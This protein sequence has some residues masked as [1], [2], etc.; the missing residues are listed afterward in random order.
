[1]ERNRGLPADH[2]FV[3]QFRARETGAALPLEG[4]VEHLDSGQAT[5][6]D[7]PQQLLRFIEQTL[8]RIPPGPS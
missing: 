2:A 3:V 4:R 8:G 5:H 6:F 1:M 7:S